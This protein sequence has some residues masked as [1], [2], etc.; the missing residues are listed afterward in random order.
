MI[1]S[2][3]WVN[4]IP[5]AKK[6]SDQE[7]TKLDFNRWINTIPKSKPN[8]P[9]KKYSL[10]TVLF[11]L[12]LIFVSMIKNETRGL[13]RDIYNLKTSINTLKFD[14]HQATLD[15]EVITS[16]E[17]ISKLANNYLELDLIVYK[18]SQIKSLNEIHVKE[19]DITKLS[20]KTKNENKLSKV[21][22]K[23]S[24]EVKIHITKK[25]KDKQDELQKLQNLAYKPKELPGEIKLQLVKKIEAKKD[26]LKK[27]YSNPKDLINPEKIKSW[28]GVQLVKAFLGI[29]II[30][31][32]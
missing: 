18:K 9:I 13:Q 19:K 2:N 29:P 14:L 7:E 27:I 15:Y 21:S 28:A 6:K 31:G 24:K 12:G 1:D 3:R 17:N 4:T 32:K 5:S 23:L 20:E 10:V 26:E 16:P 22:K 8:R 11:V 25:I 30:P